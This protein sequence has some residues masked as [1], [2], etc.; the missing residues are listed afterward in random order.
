MPDSDTDS[1]CETDC[2][3]VSE[4]VTVT[5]TLTQSHG[6]SDNENQN[7]MFDQVN[8]LQWKAGSDIVTCNTD[9]TSKRAREVLHIRGKGIAIQ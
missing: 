4:W 8:G 1:D 9:M 7:V 5:V 3:W 6:H 2:D